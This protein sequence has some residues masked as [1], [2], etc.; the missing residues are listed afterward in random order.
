MAAKKVHENAV[1]YGE[2]GL[3]FASEDAARE[4]I[5]REEL[6]YDV[7]GVH[8]EAPDAFVVIKLTELVRRMDAQAQAAHEEREQEQTAEADAA[9]REC[10]LVTFAPASSDNDRS[11]VPLAVNGRQVQVP[12]NVPTPLPKP[13]IEAAKNA[14]MER[15]ESL[16]GR[17]YDRALRR[18]GEMM[19]RYPFSVGE[20]VA[21][22]EYEK[23]LHEGTKTARH[24]AGIKLS[25]AE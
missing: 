24:E 19:S 25:D 7:W 21:Y 10:Y 3:P 18:T 6:S 17:E 1:R 20:K 13:L 4:Y 12:R 8:R 22:K 2:D 11:F 9:W 14:Q 15:I 5:K 23:I 16:A